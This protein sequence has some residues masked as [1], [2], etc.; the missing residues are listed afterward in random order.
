[1]KRN[2]YTLQKAKF[3]KASIQVRY[4]AVTGHSCTSMTDKDDRTSS[5][6]G[7]GDGRVD[8]IV[9]SWS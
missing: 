2:P 3:L 4:R 8:F 6:S 7:K 5:C 1:M 9:K